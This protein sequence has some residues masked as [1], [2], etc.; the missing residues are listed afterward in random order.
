M[1]LSPH[2]RRRRFLAGLIPAVVLALSDSIAATGDETSAAAEV[3]PL[4]QREVLPLLQAWRRAEECAAGIPGGEAL[5]GR[6]DSMLP[7][8]PDST[9]L[10]VRRMRMDELRAGMVV[11]FIGDGGRPVAHTLV[12]NGPRGWLAQ[13]LGNVAPDRTLVRSQN[14]LGTVVRAFVPHPQEAPTQASKVSSGV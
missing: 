11:V 5:V 4:P 12:A 10:V 9:V 14:Y 6:G 3:A 8:Y 13:G 2:L 1:L 7:V